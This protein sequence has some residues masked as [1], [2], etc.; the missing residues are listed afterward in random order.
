MES[1]VFAWGDKTGGGLDLGKDNQP[2]VGH[3]EL[4]ESVGQAGGDI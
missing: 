3:V 4:K 2:N 1:G